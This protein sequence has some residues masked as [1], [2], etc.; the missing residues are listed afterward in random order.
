[1]ACQLVSEEVVRVIL[2]EVFNRLDFV[3]RRCGYLWRL[4]VVRP[5][6]ILGRG[7]SNG[8]PVPCLAVDTIAKQES[9]RVPIL[10]TLL[11]S[12]INKLSSSSHASN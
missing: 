10:P 7:I 6:R 5:E 8:P 1:M 3:V 12:T 4:G 2:Y 9:R 11:S